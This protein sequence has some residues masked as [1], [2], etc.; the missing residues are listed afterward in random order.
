MSDFLQAARFTDRERREPHQ[1]AAWQWAWQLLSTEQQAEFLEMFRAAPD[2]PSGAAPLA[3]LA[4]W[5]K[6]KAMAKAA[7]ARH[8]ELVAAQAALES[9]WFKHQ[10]GRNNLFGLKGSG[11]KKTTTEVVNGKTVTITAEFKDFESIQAGVEYLVERWYRDWD[12]HQGVNRNAFRDGAARDLVAQGYATD[13]A[14]AEKLIALMN[15]HEPLPAA[16]AVTAAAPAQKPEGRGNP[17]VVPWFSQRD[18]RTDQAM[19][20]C[21]S[22]SCAMVVAYLRPGALQGPNGDDAYLKTVQRFGD[23]IDAQVQLKAL[24]HYGIEAEFMQTADF[25]TVEEQIAKGYPVPLG[26]IHR[27]PVERPSGG[28]HWLVAVGHT[29]THLVVHDPFGEADLVSGATLGSTCRYGHYS[30]QN[31]GRRWMVKPNGDGTYAF[32]P[33]HGWAVLVRAVKAG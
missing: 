17:L 30:R 13:P 19:R 28:G 22:S 5:A 31:F 14:Y 4:D 7:G 23:T 2:A 15:Q 10:S 3:A 32:A 8:P 25:K 1:D 26:F 18:S 11:T 21:F 33:G 20:M 16:P 9:G 27:G 6:I 29:P 12:G 24:A